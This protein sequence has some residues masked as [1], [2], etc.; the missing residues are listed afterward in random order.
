MIKVGIDI[1]EIDRIK[2]SISNYNFLTKILGNDEFN[3]LSKKNFPPQSVA[4]NFCAKE[5][6]AKAIGTGFREFGFR[7]VQIVKDINGKPFFKL[8]GKA[9]DISLKN[10]YNFSISISHNK[11]MA[12][13][14]VI[15]ESRL[16][17][18]DIRKI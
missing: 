5:A 10:G 14:V 4:G 2:K 13:A 12:T 15:C 11:T 1:I 16:F 9:L 6:F 3:E 17:E 8:S 7:D 18:N